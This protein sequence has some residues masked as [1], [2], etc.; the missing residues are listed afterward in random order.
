MNKLKSFSR[1]D[2]YGNMFSMEFF[3]PQDSVP[4]MVIIPEPDGYNGADTSNHPGEAR[5]TDT[6][7]A[8]LTPGENVVNAEAS[9]IPGNQEK[10]DA[11]NEQ[12]RQI[13][14]AQ[15]GPIPTYQS[16]GGP[17]Y[18][19]DGQLKRFLA[20][21]E[22][23][24]NEA[25]LDSA[26][27]PT[28]GY[29]STYGV[30]MGDKISDAQANQKLMRDMAMV[31]QDYNKLVD[32]DLN[33]NQQ[34]AVKSL[35]FNI[36]GPQF[37][38]SK[39]RAAL[40]A[41]DFDAFQREASEFRMADGQVLPGLE[42]RRA[43]EMSLFNRPYENRSVGPDAFGVNRRRVSTVP[44]PNTTPPP[45]PDMTD[46]TDFSDVEDMS[47]GSPEY[48]SF[49][50]TITTPTGEIINPQQKAIDVYDT[51]VALQA[52]KAE[53][54]ALKEK[55][56]DAQ[57][58]GVNNPDLITQLEQ[59][60]NDVKS[61]TQANQKALSEKESADKLAAKEKADIMSRADAAIAGTNA[62]PKPASNQDKQ[63]NTLA[64]LANKNLTSSGQTQQEQNNQS[65]TTVQNAGEDV[66]KEDPSFVQQIAN[67]FTDFFGDLFDPKE[68]ARMAVL[69]AGSRAL[70]Y[71]HD[72]SL[73]YSA[74]QYM[75]RYDAE[76]SARKKFAT[77]KDTIDTYTASSIQDYLETGDMSK[78]VSKEKGGSSITGQSGTRF[79]TYTGTEV[80]VYKVGTGENAFLAV[81]DSA[82]NLRSLNDAS[83]RGRYEVV[84]DNVHDSTKV[85]SA[86]QTSLA[87]QVSEINKTISDD[88]QKLDFSTE[89]LASEAE[90]LYTSTRNNFRM[91]TKDARVLS[92]EII[93]AQKDFLEDMKKHKQNPTEVRKP[94]SIEGYY[95]KRIVTLKTK[96]VISQNDIKE[97][98]AENFK[99]VDDS[100]MALA[101]NQAG[102]DVNQVAPLYREMWKTA[103]DNWR[104]MKSHG[105][106]TKGTDPGYDPFIAWTQ[107]MLV[108]DPK[109]LELLEASNMKTKL[110]D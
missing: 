82:G 91:K 53:Q 67:G 38:N 88:E 105:S 60:N 20:L 79:D 44:N 59:A 64:E 101:A 7:P 41:G 75:K 103:K 32:V 31:D 26:G 86:F 102:Q 77:D 47:I 16:D 24:R 46:A 68:V 81:Q 74:K 39:A 50:K 87:N 43:R 71:D 37:A 1:K 56:Q 2:R 109:A 28:I 10:I 51:G 14:K 93:G 66:L 49:F 72:S 6:V 8:W 42:A 11:M 108:N 106:F 96:G 58:R 65:E 9:R 69:Y 34:T 36:G 104:N 76:V 97:T 21:E 92:R 61:A 83:V 3:E 54:A 12:G 78:L 19:A 48:G 90:L 33:P 45:A 73:G 100:M 107:A 17:V 98:T 99:A 95:N 23:K 13:Q 5:G 85:R 35:L 55:V 15:G 52:A 29:G 89:Q 27:V 63:R 80:P 22:G 30:K 84:N 70:G 94:T 57:R 62:P 4:M 18:A 40:N 25:Y 110:D